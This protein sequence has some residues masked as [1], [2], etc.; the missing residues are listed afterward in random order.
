MA[1]ISEYD[2]I[3]VGGGLVGASLAAALAPLPLRVAV[4]EA[5][6]FGNLSQPSFDDRIT[7][8]S[9]GSR[10]IYGSM[11][12]WP[13]LAAEATP[14]RRIH[15][16]DR[17]RFG[18][19]RLGAEEAG[20]EALGHVTPNRAIGRALGEF[21]ATKSN[22]AMLAPAKLESFKLDAAGAEAVVD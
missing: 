11:G 7:A 16:S 2:L 22:L 15:V 21:I 8:L 19:T 4:I 9:E 14:I 20:V 6:A 18:I 5:V 1:S 17:G 10:R 3:I 13:A 12:L